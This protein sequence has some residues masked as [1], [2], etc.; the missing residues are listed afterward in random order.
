MKSSA[1]RFY[2]PRRQNSKRQSMLLGWRSCRDSLFTL[3]TVI[4]H[5]RAQVRNLPPGWVPVWLRATEERKKKKIKPPRAQKSESRTWR[6]WASTA[7]DW[8]RYVFS[9]FL[10]VHPACFSVCDWCFVLRV[11]WASV[12]N[13]RD[14]CSCFVLFS[15]PAIKMS[16]SFL[17]SNSTSHI[18]PFS[19]V[20]ELVGE[21]LSISFPAFMSYVRHS[22]VWWSG[23]AAA[24]LVINDER[25]EA[26][27]LF[28]RHSFGHSDEE[29]F[30][31][32]QFWAPCDSQTVSVCQHCQIPLRCFKLTCSKSIGC[33]LIR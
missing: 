12:S 28:L 32:R 13:K 17:N 14:F 30:L 33:P 6:G 11:V 23:W 5:L 25:L 8:A 16:P 4:K 26:F 22:K 29:R 24:Y 3:A 10:F 27:H 19:A 31:Q 1:P 18:W 2:T 20:A 7:F 15:F 21:D 9:C